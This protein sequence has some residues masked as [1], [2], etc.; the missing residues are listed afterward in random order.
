MFSLVFF[1]VFFVVLFLYTSLYNVQY[2]HLNEM[3]I[4]Y[5]FISINIYIFDSHILILL[6]KCSFIH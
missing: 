1:L 5:L 3:F 2:L 6:I 4:V